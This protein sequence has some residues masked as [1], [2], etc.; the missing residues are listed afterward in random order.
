MIFF[1]SVEENK[2]YNRINLW[3]VKEKSTSIKLTNK[4]NPCNWR[5]YWMC[6]QIMKH[7][8][9]ENATVKMHIVAMLT[10]KLWIQSVCPVFI[11]QLKFDLPSPSLTVSENFPC[12]WG[13]YKDWI[14]DSVS[15][16]STPA[17][18]HWLYTTFPFSPEFP[19]FFHWQTWD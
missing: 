14:S 10:S 11:Q 7:S 15:E 3:N 18:V 2:I 6:W 19:L 8:N 12:G 13:K 17:A 1:L 16:N 4:V 9:T 5:F